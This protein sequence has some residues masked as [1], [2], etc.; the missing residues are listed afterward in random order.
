MQ[1]VA[2]ILENA[3]YT[4]QVYLVDV[5]SSPRFR[6]E[7]DIHKLAGIESTEPFFA[8]SVLPLDF[9]I[10]D[11]NGTKDFAFEFA[12]LASERGH[13][14]VRDYLKAEANLRNRILYAADVGIP[15]IEIFDEF[16]FQRRQRVV[17][18]LSIVIMLEQT[19]E[20]QSFALQCLN[21]LLQTLGSLDAESLP[22]AE[23]QPSE[24]MRLQVDRTLNTSRISI[25]ENGKSRTAHFEYVG[26]TEF[27]MRWLDPWV[28]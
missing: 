12:E 3:H 6:I 22:L 2:G 24:G 9:T 23:T 26:N 13:S 16:I 27:Q 8:E 7:I 15:K 11:Q 19:C 21:A 17:V 4:P 1:I 10:S 14:R 28:F 20:I 18:I 25:V 5:D